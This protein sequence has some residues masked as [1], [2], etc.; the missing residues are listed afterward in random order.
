MI[1]RYHPHNKPAKD[2]ERVDEEDTEAAEGVDAEAEGIIQEEAKAKGMNLWQQH[3]SKLSFT[4]S[5]NNNNYNNRRHDKIKTTI[6]M[7]LINT[8]MEPRCCNTIKT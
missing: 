7:T 5:K 4:M 1:P 3:T 2:G 6:K 8:K